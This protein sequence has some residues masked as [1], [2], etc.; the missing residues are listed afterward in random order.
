[1]Y[2]YTRLH[3]SNQ[4]RPDRGGPHPRGHQRAT[5]TK[6]PGHMETIWKIL[7]LSGAVSV[8]IFLQVLSC[9]AFGNNWCAACIPPTG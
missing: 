3:S 5:L 8:A 6:C 7:L 4:T 9:F 2:N 1:M